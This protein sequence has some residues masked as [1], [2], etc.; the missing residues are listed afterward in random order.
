MAAILQQIITASIVGV[1]IGYIALTNALTKTE[2][3]LSYIKKS[4]ESCDQKIQIQQ[5]QGQ[6]IARMDIEI[7]HNQQTTAR[8]ERQ[9]NANLKKNN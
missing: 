9:I 8:I 3:E 1:A 4:V 5:D 2:T 6:A 7:K